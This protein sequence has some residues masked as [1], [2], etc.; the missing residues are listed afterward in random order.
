MTS[1]CSCKTAVADGYVL[2][3]PCAAT[4]IKRDYAD[5]VARSVASLTPLQIASILKPGG[6]K[7]E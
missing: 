1:G 7:N 6:F 2:C 4:V 5:L 3:P